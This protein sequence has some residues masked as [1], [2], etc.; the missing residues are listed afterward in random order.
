MDISS[1]DYSAA[2]VAHLVYFGIAI[3]ATVV[4]VA[5]Y[6]MVT[7]H[8]EFQLIREGNSAAAISLGGALLGYTIPLA[9]AVSQ[10]EGVHDMLL[11][12]GVALVAQLV[13]YGASRL[14]LPALSSDVHQGKV[15]SG[16]FLAAMSVCVGML[17]AAAMTA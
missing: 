1:F 3:V 7:P 12:S 9:K 11:W 5:I 8:R 16:I 13:A 4:F 6:V 14:I 17:N 10:S 2:I 15:A